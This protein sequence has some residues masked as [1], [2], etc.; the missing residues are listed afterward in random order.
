MK[1]INVFDYSNDIMRELQKGILITTKKDGKVNSMTV[2]WGHLGIEWGLPV[3]VCYIRTGR[4]THKMLENSEFTVNIPLDRSKVG[5]ITSYCGSHSGRDIDK[6]TTLGLHLIEG[7]EVSVPAIKEL[8]LTL[9]CKV[10]YKQ[11]QDSSKLPMTIQEHFYPADKDSK[12]FS[13]NRDQ[14]EMF[15]GQIVKAYIVE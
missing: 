1:E 4:Y 12:N 2:S 3:F 5:K 14:H 6:I 13:I 8:P 11:L 9:E 15:Y 10:I 7:Q